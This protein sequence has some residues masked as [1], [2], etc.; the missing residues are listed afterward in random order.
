MAKCLRCG[1]GPEW[2]QGKVPT[3]ADTVTIR[4]AALRAERDRYRKA[5]EEI[6]EKASHGNLYRDD[7]GDICA[8]ISGLARRAL[9]GKEKS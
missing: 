5:L 7:G 6:A 2:L 8:E 4:N 9:E 1:A 3:S